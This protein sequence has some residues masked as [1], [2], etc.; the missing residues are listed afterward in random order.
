M[1]SPEGGSNQP[2]GHASE[3]SG[4]D[5]EVGKIFQDFWPGTVVRRSGN[6]TEIILPP[7]L[8]NPGDTSKQP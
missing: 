6:E 5:L 8:D 4:E 3:K 7:E 1:S 2:D